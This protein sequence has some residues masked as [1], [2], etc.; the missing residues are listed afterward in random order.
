MRPLLGVER[1]ADEI[2]LRRRGEDAPSA[3]WAKAGS[4]ERSQAGGKGDSDTHGRPHNAVEA[5]RC[6]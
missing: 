6:R 5:E 2:V 1:D 3:A 4:G